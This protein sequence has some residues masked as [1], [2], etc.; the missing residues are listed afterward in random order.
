MAYALPG[1]GAGAPLDEVALLL[2]AE[3]AAAVTGALAGAGV[4]TLTRGV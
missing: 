2:Q 3:S 4:G 1:G